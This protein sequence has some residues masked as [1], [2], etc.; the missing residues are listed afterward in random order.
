MFYFGVIGFLLLLYPLFAVIFTEPDLKILASGWLGLILNTATLVSIC[1]FVSSLTKNP[2]L[3]YLASAFSVILVIFSS[4]IPS[5][6]EE[7]KRKFSCHLCC[8]DFC[9]FI[10]DPVCFRK[11]EVENINEK[12]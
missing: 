6:P 11:Q 12:I 4:F 8:P 5:A 1:L 3:S 10:F 7:Y 9:V 2:V